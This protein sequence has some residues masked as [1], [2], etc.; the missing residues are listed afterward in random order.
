MCSSDLAKELAKIFLEQIFRL[1]G[2]PSVII[3]DR[4]PQFAAKFWRKFCEILDIDV[5]LSSAYHPQTDGQTE[6]MNQTLEQYLRCLLSTLSSDW[7]SCLHIA[8][9]AYNS[10]K[11][12]S[13]GS[14]PFFCVTGSNPRNLP[15]D[16]SPLADSSVPAVT[17]HVQQLARIHQVTLENLTKTK[18]KTKIQADKHRTKEP[19]YVPGALVWLSTKNI[20]LE[21][22]RKL[23][24]RYIGPFEIDKVL[25]PVS[26]RLKLPQ[27]LAIHP[28]FH[29]SLI[30][31]FVEGTRPEPPPPPIHVDSHSEFEVSKILDSKRV[32]GK[33]Y[34]LVDWKGYG[35]DDR[36]WEPFTN[37]HSPRLLRLFH[38][39]HPLKPKPVSGSLRRGTVTRSHSCPRKIVRL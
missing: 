36:S 9:F 32:N 4:G 31:P 28:T 3:S 24:P 8:E 22:S 34:Y 16:L 30:K 17:E 10:Q 35:P 2:L 23:Q 20:Q 37:L 6:R 5:R 19:P 7:V 39:L 18:L 26:V 12:S 38:R 11:H 13:T 27:D 29:V 1:H 25:N 15:I 33:L 14:S 21:G